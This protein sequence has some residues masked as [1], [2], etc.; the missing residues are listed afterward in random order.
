MDQDKNSWLRD[1][2]FAAIVEIAKEDLGKLS[3]V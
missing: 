3:P 1:P 2:E